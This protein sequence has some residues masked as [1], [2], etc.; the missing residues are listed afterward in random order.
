MSE[1]SHILIGRLRRDVM[2][3]GHGN[4]KDLKAE[5]EA[6]VKE[7]RAAETFV[8]AVEA[9]FSEADHNWDPEGTNARSK[10]SDVPPLNPGAGEQQSL[11][12]SDRPFTTPRLEIEKAN[13]E[14]ADSGVLVD[15]GSNPDLTPTGK[16]RNEE[17]L[18]KG[19]ES[20][21]QSKPDEKAKTDSLDAKTK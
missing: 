17:E 5:A 19:K 9:Y 2:M 21:G 16:A 18:A 7:G 14:Q 3:L 1:T 8:I 13:Q 4:A 15:T 6:A 11:T 10:P 12:T 20:G